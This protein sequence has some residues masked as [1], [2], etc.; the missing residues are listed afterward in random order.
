MLKKDIRKK[1]LEVKESK[2]RVLTEQTIV[3]NRIMTIFES[4]NN[5]KNFNKLP[6][7]KKRKLTESLSKE[8][9]FINKNR[10]LVEETQGGIVGMLKGV[11][12]NAFYSIIETM[13][14]PIVDSILGGIGLKGPFK[15]FLVSSFTN[16]KML[17]GWGDCRIMTEVV[18]DGIVETLVMQVQENLGKEAAG[19]SMLR[20]AILRAFKS[21]TFYKSISD[22]IENVVC[23]VFSKVTGN[24]AKVTEKLKPEASV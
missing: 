3:H 21:Q 24:V 17:K 9:I 12:G 23:S 18:V 8:L 19:Y 10:L 22:S 16:E 13:I 7:L 20:N 6:K 14:E 2:D 11:F 1:L 5:I 4:E 15:K